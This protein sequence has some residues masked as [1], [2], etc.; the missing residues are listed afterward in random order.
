[1]KFYAD[2]SFLFSYYASDAHS[3]RADKWRQ[4]HP[5]PLLSS[6]LNRLE[7]RNGLELA[8]FQKRLTQ[9]ETA[10][11]WRTVES[12]FAAGLLVPADLLLADLTHQAEML[13]ADHK[14]GRAHV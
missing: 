9:T 3:S 10:E 13:A 4:S 2:T 12:D 6:S 7:L 1:M 14:I 5:F 11:L 8:V